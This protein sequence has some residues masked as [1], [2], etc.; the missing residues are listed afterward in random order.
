MK[1]YNQMGNATWTGEEP[2]MQMLVLK[3][4]VY[5]KVGDGGTRVV[6]RWRIAS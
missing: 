1:D 4:R 6:S 5:F 3:E 2:E